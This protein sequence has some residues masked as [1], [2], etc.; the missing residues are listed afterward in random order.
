MTGRSV[1]YGLFTVAC[2]AL[3]TACTT[4]VDPSPHPGVLRV[5]LKSN[6]LDTNIVILSD[7]TRFSRYDSFFARVF[8][9]RIYHGD[10]YSPLY[11]NTGID[12]IESDTVNLLAREWLTGVPINIRDSVAI[13][14]TN[15][16][17]RKF[18]IFEWVV[19]PGNYDLLQFSLLADEIATYVPKLY[20]NPLQLPPDV[21]PQVIF[22]AAFSVQDDKT[23]EINIEIS[24]FKSLHRF[25][26]SFLFDRQMKIVSIRTF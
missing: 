16:R 18:I 7:T 13:T 19:P 26:D 20:I 3:F 4:G 22:P 6:D 15:S 1:L 14:A 12:R 23:T 10:N 2:A 5:T 11:T 21:G 24:P 25:Q 8:G 9:G 17:Y